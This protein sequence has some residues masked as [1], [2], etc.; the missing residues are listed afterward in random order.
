[1]VA[2]LAS[3]PTTRPLPK[4][5]LRFSGSISMPPPVETT[6]PPVTNTPIPPT[7]T[8][9]PTGLCGD[10]NDDNTI[11]SR[12]ALWVLWFTAGLVSELEND[13][14]VNG[15]GNVDSRD[16]ALI[17]QTEAGALASPCV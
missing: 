8:T 5:S 9:P 13:G 2:G 7:A 3:S 15:D 1:M 11:D 10:V 14:D 16:A 6:P 12:D 17:L 4:A